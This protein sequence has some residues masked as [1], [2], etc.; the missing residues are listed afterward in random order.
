M[1]ERDKTTESKQD[2]ST[3]DLLRE[4]YEALKEGGYNPVAQIS[5]YII[6]EDPT[7]I[8]DYKNARGIICKVE[9]EQLVEELVKFYIDEH[10]ES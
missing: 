5:G 8:T 2:E 1:T 4:V 7:Y 3:G 6:S 9:R 10:S